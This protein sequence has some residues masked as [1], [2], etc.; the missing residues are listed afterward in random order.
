MLAI[1]LALAVQQDALKPTLTRPDRAVAIALADGRALAEIDPQIP[2]FTKWVMCNKPNEMSPV[3]LGYA[4]NTALN[5]AGNTYRPVEVGKGVYRLDLATEESARIPI[6]LSGDLP[7]QIPY[8]K[9]VSSNIGSADISPSGVRAVLGARGDLFT[10]P[11]K[12]GPTRNLTNTQGIRERSPSWSPDGKWIAYYSEA[13][14]EY[15]LTVRAQDG[16]GEP[17][18]LTRKSKIWQFEPVWSPDSKQIAFGSRDRKLRVVNG[19]HN[20]YWKAI[21]QRMTADTG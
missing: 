19:I 6:S 13:T 12:H 11:A 5:F 9:D 4:T 16:S 2:L 17:R 7:G 1:I 8:F 21:P 10:V 3:A 20:Y 15:E 14:G 18:Q